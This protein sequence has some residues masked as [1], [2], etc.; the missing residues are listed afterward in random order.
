MTNLRDPPR[1]IYQFPAETY[2][3]CEECLLCLV[4]VVPT[5]QG[6]E[7]GGLQKASIEMLPS[8]TRPFQCTHSSLILH[9]QLVQVSQLEI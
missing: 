5:N 4:N 1:R 9:Q 8:S 3:G 2:V 6:E 7:K